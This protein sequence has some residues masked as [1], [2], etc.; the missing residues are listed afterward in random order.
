MRCMSEDFKVDRRN[1]LKGV[2]AAAAVGA[3]PDVAQAQQPPSLEVMRGKVAT[4]IAALES[5][6]APLRGKDARI[7]RSF[8]TIISRGNEFAAS[9]KDQYRAQR[10]MAHI[11]EIV[12]LFANLIS[13]SVGH[14]LDG[15][16]PEGKAV[17]AIRAAV[18]AFDA[19][20]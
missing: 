19:V 17:L 1:F 6:Y 3:V 4:V 8:E 13:T 10:E 18:K 16:P 12:D 20:K 2:G 5:A 7:D 11:R 9:Q 14:N 15:N